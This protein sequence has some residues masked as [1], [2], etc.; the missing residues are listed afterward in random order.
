MVIDNQVNVGLTRVLKTIPKP[1]VGQRP[2]SHMS[3]Q[4]PRA[5]ATGDSAGAST[6]GS[7]CIISASALLSLANDPSLTCRPRWYFCRP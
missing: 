3:E 6:F 7:A 5:A 4:G 2:F 1:G